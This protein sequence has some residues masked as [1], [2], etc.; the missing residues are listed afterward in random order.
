MVMLKVVD[1]IILST[2]ELTYCYEATLLCEKGEGKFQVKIVMT[3]VKITI[4]IIMLILVRSLA[5]YSSTLRHSGY[6]T[7]SQ[8]WV[9][10]VA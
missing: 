5:E 9:C 4:V 3:V 6:N 10:K 7:R 8:H 1:F 2:I